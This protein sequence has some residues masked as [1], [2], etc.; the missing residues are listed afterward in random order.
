MSTG[1]RGRG[2]EVRRRLLICTANMLASCQ[3]SS[4][5][6]IGSMHDVKSSLCNKIKARFYNY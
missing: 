1:A 6:Y 4:V 2:G 3:Y 5:N